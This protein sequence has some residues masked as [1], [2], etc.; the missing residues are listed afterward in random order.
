MSDPQIKGL[1]LER[2]HWIEQCRFQARVKW[3]FL[4]LGLLLGA[5]LTISLSAAAKRQQHEAVYNTNWCEAHGGMAE[6]INSDGTRTD[7]VTLAYAI[8]AEFAD[9]WYQSIGQ[10]LHYA[11]LQQKLP[12]ILLIVEEQKQCKH[13]DAAIHTLPFVRFQSAEYGEVPIKLWAQG[14][15]IC[16][17]AKRT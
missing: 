1:Q 13:L 9:G 4:V 14:H 2:N 17:E 3:V 15:E 11:R 5:G 16:M 12:G 10:A 7:C 8:E 6:V